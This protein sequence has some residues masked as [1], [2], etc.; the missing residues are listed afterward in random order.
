MADYVAIADAIIQREGRFTDHPNDRG[1]ATKYGITLRTLE[2]W[3]KRPVTVEDVK[4]LTLDEAREIYIH[5]YIKAPGFD[6]V[7]ESML[8]LQL[9]DFGV[10]SGPGAAIL[11]LQEI[12][13]VPA[14]GKLGPRT[15]EALSQADLNKVN[16]AL[17][18]RRLM[19]IARIVK[20]DNKQVAFLMGWIKRALEF[21]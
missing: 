18:K 19:M 13:G 16:I 3:R 5:K 10:N 15:L 8:Q 12:L 20:R 14:D 2:W 7:P 21:I 1:G 4:N 17:L 9:V 6:K 11:N